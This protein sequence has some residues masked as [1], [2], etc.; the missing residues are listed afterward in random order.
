MRRITLAA[1][2][3]FSF[4]VMPVYAAGLFCHMFSCTVV[5]AGSMF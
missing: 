1:A 4:A 3:A 2:L 5:N